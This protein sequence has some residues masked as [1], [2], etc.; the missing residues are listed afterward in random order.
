MQ[1]SRAP[2]LAAIAFGLLAAWPLASHAD[3]YPIA[4]QTKLRVS[5]VQWVPSKGEYQPWGAI[6]GEFT[7]SSTGTLSLPLVGTIS[8]GTMDNVELAAKISDQLKDKT[9]LISAPNTTIEILEYPPIYIVGSVTTPGEYKFRPGMTVL[10]ALALSG[11]RYR[12]ATQDGD[13][14]Q[15]GMLGDLQSFREDIL[16]TLARI[17]RLEAESSSAKDIS[18][19]ADLTSRAGDPTVAEVMAQERIVFNA[20]RNE[21][22]RQLESLDELR[23]LFTSEID[24]LEKKTETLDSRIKLVSDELAGVRSLVERGIAT[25]SRRSELELA[26]SN[27]QSNRLDEITAAMRARQNLSEATRNALSLKDKHQTSVSVELQEAQANLERLKIK[28]DVVKKVLVV[29]GTSPISE[30]KRENTVEP[31]LTF[32]I[33]RQS[34]GKAEEISASEQT[35][36]KPNDVVKVALSEPAGKRPTNSTVSGLTQ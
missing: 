14:G 15:I 20:R 35:P 2:L 8:T 19:P 4:P 10:Q 30:S 36:L 5:V 24:I 23:K 6:G 34:E 17:S 25:V 33:V 27:L 7:V 21:L 1:S 31:N 22:S 3:T 16:R 29:S 9:G 32:T 11:G 12:A 26:V 13:K 18:F 28:E